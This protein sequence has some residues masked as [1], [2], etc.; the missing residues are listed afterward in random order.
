MIKGILIAGLITF[1]SLTNAA[2]VVLCDE[3]TND[4]L[5]RGYSG[6]GAE[7]IAA[8]INTAY[9]QVFKDS[10]QG[11][12]L[13]EG[14]EPSDWVLISEAEKTQVISLLSFGTVKPQ[15]NI[16][17]FLISIFGGGSQTIANMA[18]IAQHYITRVSELGLNSVSAGA[19]QTAC[20]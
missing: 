12:D 4:P 18:T 20:Q 9:R 19:A 17:T 3:I 7:A 15:G 16:R 6:M 2:N 5:G 8:D 13:F 10:V 11:A 14:I 1:S